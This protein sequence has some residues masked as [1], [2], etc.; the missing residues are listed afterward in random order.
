MVKN[1]LATQETWVQSLGL[2]NAL[3]KGMTTHSSILAWKIQRSLTGHSP[4][5]CKRV[6]HDWLTSTHI[7]TLS[8]IL[9]SC[10]TY[11]SFNTTYTLY[12]TLI[13]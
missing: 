9:L 8:I 6:G 7:H 10:T 3:E 1:V 13:H 12:Y 5:T 4:C 2:E 11:T